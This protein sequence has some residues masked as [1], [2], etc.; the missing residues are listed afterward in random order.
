MAKTANFGW[1]IVQ[2]SGW[3]YGQKPGFEKGLEPREIPTRALRNLV[4]RVGGVVYEDYLEADEAAHELMFPPGHPE[5]MLY[6]NFMGTFSEKKI[7][8]LRIAI[9]RRV[10]VP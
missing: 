7:D 8:G 3:G 10:V 4:E 2:H 9:P 6:P 1:T 5:H